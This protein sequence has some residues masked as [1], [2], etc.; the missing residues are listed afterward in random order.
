MKI[1]TI[2]LKFFKKYLNYCGT[3]SLWAFFV[4]FVTAKTVKYANNPAAIITIKS[5][6][7]N[8]MLPIGSNKNP[9]P[10]LN[11]T[12]SINTSSPAYIATAAITEITAAN[13]QDNPGS[14]LYNN[15]PE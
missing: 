10:N 8:G 14:F 4:S 6:N 13:T 12:P 5:I 9:F 15:A 3:L 2:I 11:K 7:A 1:A